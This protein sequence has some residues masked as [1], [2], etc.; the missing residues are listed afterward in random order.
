M[1]DKYDFVELKV[2]VG[3]SCGGTG[4]IGTCEL[5]DRWRPCPV[6]QSQRVIYKKAIIEGK[7]YQEDQGN[8]FEAQLYSKRQ[9]EEYWQQSSSS[10]RDQKITILVVL[11]DFHV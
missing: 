4:E 1:K 9:V 3:H 8:N 6:F 10:S 2:L 11:V 5:G 7:T